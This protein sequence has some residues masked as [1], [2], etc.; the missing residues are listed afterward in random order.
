MSHHV[1]K[2]SLFGQMTS[3]RTADTIPNE[4]GVGA[5]ETRKLGPGPRSTAKKRRS[6]LVV[7][8]FVGVVTACA[9]IWHF[10]NRVEAPAAT[11]A[12]PA[13]PVSVETVEAQKMRLWND[14]SGRLRA[15]NSAEI[16]PEVS[17][18]ITEVRFRDGQSVKAG[19][20]LLVIDPRPFEAAVAR[21]K[22]RIAS[23]EAN[24][25]FTKAEQ[26]RN[27]SLLQTRVIAQREF[28]QTDSRNQSSAAELL[29]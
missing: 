22:A 4:P 11:L 21:A 18:R 12:A 15:V 8:L 25:K 26:L 23:A 29:A 24:L 27:T 28:D 19:D 1:L 6:P 10:V 7:A 20:I 2:P 9:V 17:G 3:S 16:R 13:T 5:S 14:F